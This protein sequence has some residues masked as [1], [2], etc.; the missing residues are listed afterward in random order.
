MAI[1]SVGAKVWHTAMAATNKCL[2]QMSKSQVK[3]RTVY[4]KAVEDFTET[5]RQ[6]ARLNQQFRQASFG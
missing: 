6:L 1:T 2:A 5:A 4:E 3:P